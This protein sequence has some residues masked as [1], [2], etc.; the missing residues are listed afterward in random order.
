MFDRLSTLTR[1]RNVHD[2]ERIVIVCNGPSLNQMDLGFLRD[3]ITFG[4]N[5]IHLGLETFG[6]YPRYLAAVNDKV[7]GQTAD[8]LRKMTAVKFISDRS[9]HLLPADA[10][11]FHIHTTRVREP[12]C[13]DITL[14]V[15]EGH[16][17]TFVAL[18]LAYYMGARE[19]VLI[20]MDH[21]FTLNGPPNSTQ[22]MQGHDPNHFSPDYFANKPWD[23]ANLAQ[24]EAS[25]KIARDAYEADGRRII[26]ATLGGACTIF[27]KADYREVFGKGA[28]RPQPAPRSPATGYSRDGMGLLP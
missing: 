25:Y 5:K 4:L 24:S 2:G 20:G 12:F 28:P 18:Q 8:V 22:V 14:G 26:D 10:L 9:A 23:A 11:T 7:I 3:E 6:F 16:T 15:R 19:V 1:F 21:R 13:H 27:E 17:V